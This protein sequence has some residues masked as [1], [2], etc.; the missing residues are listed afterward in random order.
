M[1]AADEHLVEQC[2]R[3]FRAR[4]RLERERADERVADLRRR[5]TDVACR[6]AREL[7][8]RRVWL[9]GSLAWGGAAADS[10]VDLLVEGLPAAAWSRAHAIAEEVLGAPVDLVR[11]EEAPSGL[12]DRVEAEGRLLHER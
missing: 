5:A 2:A 7:G 12:V 1:R 3:G 8:V 9:F 4:R 10:D 6:L 11:R